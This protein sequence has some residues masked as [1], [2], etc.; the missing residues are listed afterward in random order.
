MNL[1]SP[2]RTA[3]QFVRPR[4]LAPRAADERTVALIQDAA[5]DLRSAAVEDLR[6][7]AEQLRA[8]LRADTNSRER[9]I[10]PAFALVVEAIR[11][12]VGLELFDVQ[13][14]AGLALAR[15]AV[16]EMQTGEGKT[17]AA[18]LPAFLHGLGGRGVHVVTP[19]SYLAERDWRQLAPAYELLGVSTGLL[20]EQV[21][22]EVKRAAYACDIAYG[23]GY[24]FGFDYLRDQLTLLGRRRPKL[25]RQLRDVLDG[26]PAGDAPLLQRGH[27]LA[28][29]DEIDS[30]LIDEACVPLVLSDTPHDAPQHEEAAVAAYQA[31]QSLVGNLQESADYRVDRATREV[32]L[33]DAG[34]ATIHAELSRFS[35]PA[36]ARPW[37]A[38]VENALRA[39]LLMRR[40][41]DYVV[42]CGQVLIVDEFTG[43][44]FADRSWRDGLHQAV[45]AKEGLPIRAELVSAARISRQRYFRL[46]ERLCG[47]TGTATPS[48]REFWRLYRLG[49][50]AVPPRTASQRVGLPTRFFA[51]FESKARAIVQDIAELHRSGRPVLVGSRT[52]ENSQLLAV[53]LHAENISFR[54]LNGRQDLAEAEVVAKAGE[55]QAVTIATNMAGRGTDIRLAPGV[56]QLGGLHLIGVEQH[57]TVRIDRQ[58]S[59]RVGRQGDPGTSQFFVSADDALLVDH[60]PELCRRMVAVAGERG[61]IK[62]DLSAQIARV[63]RQAESAAYAQRRRLL[64]YDA[65][66]DDVLAA[67]A[68]D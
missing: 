44:I 31:A 29:V 55:F 59:G 28:I 53:R 4:A 5:E 37:T 10:V 2:L 23:T 35:Q 39:N 30:V 36:L 11:R 18:A 68:K 64:A 15:G 48:E 1:L 45:E 13:L 21:P 14:L 62:A 8:R 40:D 54:L 60:A 49:V 65:W 67:L 58:L 22:P 47:M 46:Y 34:L 32:T 61:E 50:V 20:R 7:S 24:E 56:A 12:T 16:A 26:R 17:L 3:R 57:E 38:Y 33:T 63:Q 6:A 51:D 42:Q 9:L 66:T 41:A 43:R 27:A 19:N 52:I 25:G